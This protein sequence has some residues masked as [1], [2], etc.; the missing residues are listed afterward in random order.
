MLCDGHL[1]PLH[2]AADVHHDDDIFGRRG[3][4][5]VPECTTA[6][7]LNTLDIYI[8]IYIF[9]S[10][11]VILLLTHLTLDTKRHEVRRFDT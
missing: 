1:Q 7:P 9:F 10:V 3:C 11:F 5:D 6:S 4:L 8:Y 2:A